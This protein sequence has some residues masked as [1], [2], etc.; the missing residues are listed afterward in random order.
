MTARAILL[1]ALVFLPY[2]G[3]AEVCEFSRSDVS[4]VNVRISEMKLPGDST[5]TVIE[6]ESLNEEAR[7]GATSLFTERYSSAEELADRVD[8]FLSG[9]QDEFNIAES[10]LK[11]L[12]NRLHS[13]RPPTFVAVDMSHNRLAYLRKVASILS[14]HRYAQVNELGA[15]NEHWDELL[16]IVVGPVVYL[17][18]RE[19]ELFHATTLMAMDD[20]ALIPFHQAFNGQEQKIPEWMEKLVGRGG[21]KETGDA[22]VGGPG[23]LPEGDGVFLLGNDSLPAVSSALVSECEKLRIPLSP[24]PIPTKVEQGNNVQ[25]A[26]QEV[27]A[28]EEGSQRKIRSNGSGRRTDFLKGTKET[29]ALVARTNA[30]ARHALAYSWVTVDGAGHRWVHI[31]PL[32]YGQK[33]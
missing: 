13:R 19:P 11:L 20:Q 24:G 12:Q 28:A 23:K 3:F 9:N 1:L 29:D 14:L 4:N 25:T 10:N 2:R 7:A 18:T 26:K 6:E 8:L 32:Q 17:K 21:V 16:L 33:E 15:R 27:A 31:R 30:M 22:I 5:I